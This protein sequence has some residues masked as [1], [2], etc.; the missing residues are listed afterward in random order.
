MHDFSGPDLAPI[1]QHLRAMYRSRLLIAA[2]H[3]LPVFELL[4]E[5]PLS[6][7]TLQARLRLL[8][9]PAM[10]LFPALCAMG[11]LDH[12]A[13]GNL[14][15]TDLGRHLTQQATPNL[16]GYVG[17]EKN[18]PGVLEMVERLRNDGPQEAPGGISY[19]KEGAGPSPMDDPDLA[20]TLTLALAGRAQSLAPIV[21]NK[22]P[23]REGHLLDVA[24]GTGFFAYEWLLVNPTSTATV[25]DRPQ[26]LAV[27]AELLDAFGK[28]GRAGAERVRERVTFQPGDMLTDA[29]P[30]TDLLLAASLFHDWPTQTCQVLARRFA[31]VLRPGG[32]LWIHDGFLNDTLDGPLA[33]TEY[34][35]QLFWV[36]KGRA[37][38]RHEYRGW[39][40]QAGLEPTPENIS[41]QMDYGLIWARKP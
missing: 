34:S 38:S 28:S 5:G 19:V 12:D 4:S 41:T 15:L 16:T 35:A 30:Q 36:T 8:E 9:R 26:V 10:V 40:A 21:A 29:L 14:Q 7:S 11:L 6:F 17:L 27:A 3:H 32:A 39:L 25:F 13:Q 22:L 24:G 2:V 18:D 37:Y 20:R 33:V 31:A 23:K 1:T